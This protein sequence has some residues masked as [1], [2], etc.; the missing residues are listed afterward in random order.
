MHAHQSKAP[1]G[2]RLLP[3]PVDLETTSVSFDLH[4]QGSPVRLSATRF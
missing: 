3:A 2:S 4:L 1:L